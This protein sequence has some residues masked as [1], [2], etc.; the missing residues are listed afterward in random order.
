[1]VLEKKTKLFP[2]LL[3]TDDCSGSE[4]FTADQQVQIHLATCNFVTGVY[5]FYSFSCQ[6]MSQIRPNFRNESQ[7]ENLNVKIKKINE[8]AT[9]KVGKSLDFF[10]FF[11]AFFGLCHNKSF[12][13][14]EIISLAHFR[15]R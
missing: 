11:L 7:T 13:A 6:I 12:N 2:F 14:T 5:I 15:R 9:G 4:S 1:M 8:C 10:E 3:F